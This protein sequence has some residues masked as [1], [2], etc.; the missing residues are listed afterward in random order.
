MIMIWIGLFQVEEGVNEDRIAT[1]SEVDLP[2]GSG[3]QTA[4][5]DVRAAN[6]V[7]VE[8]SSSISNILANA[9][10][11]R[12][13]H[14]A[15]PDWR[16][17]DIIATI[18]VDNI[19]AGPL[20]F[21]RLGDTY[22]HAWHTL[23]NQRLGSSVDADIGPEAETN[24]GVIRD[25]SSSWEA[26]NTVGITVTVL[27]PGSNVVAWMDWNGDGTFANSAPERV[28]DQTLTAGA[29]YLTFSVPSGAGYSTGDFLRVRFRVEDGSA[30][31][32]RPVGLGR[33]G[34]V[35]DYFWFFTVLDKFVYLP[36]TSN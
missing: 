27:L 4:Y 15:N 6:W 7:V 1:I 35:E 31:N 28:F 13:L 3:W 34:E 33:G 10:A 29:N 12:L 14:N 23:G 21:A 11:L 19:T 5:Y 2:V 20:D 36:T 17:T 26:G 8:G 22:G 18:G 32:P 9:S 25:P 30:L 24:D 16:G